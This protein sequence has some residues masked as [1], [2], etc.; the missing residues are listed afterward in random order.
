MRYV[1][2]AAIPGSLDTYYQQ[3][4]R[5]GRDGDDAL[6]ILCYRSEDLAL[7]RYFSTSRPDHAALARV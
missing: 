7:S 4:G 1:V 3:I 5:A 6:A 2:H